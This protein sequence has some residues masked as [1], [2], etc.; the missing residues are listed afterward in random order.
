VSGSASPAPLPQ[1]DDAEYD[2]EEVGRNE[3]QLR[4]SDADDANN[5]AI[6]GSQHPTFPAPSSNQNGGRDGEY[7]RHIVEPKHNENLPAIIVLESGGDLGDFG[8]FVT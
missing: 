6:D 2:A 7:A 5:D 1:V 8:P 4:G 3:A